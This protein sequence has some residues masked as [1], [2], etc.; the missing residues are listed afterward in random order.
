MTDERVAAVERGLDRLALPGPQRRD[1]RTPRARPA[2]SSIRRP[3]VPRRDRRWTHALVRTQTALR[4]HR[5]RRDERP[6]AGRAR[7]R[8]EVTGSDRAAGSPYAA[9]ARAGHRA[10]DRPRRRQRPGGRRGRLLERDRARTT[11]SARPARPSCTAPTCSASSRGCKP[12][13]AVSGTHGKTT[14]SSMLVH[15]LRG[16]GLDPSYLVG[17]EVRS[18]GANAGWGTGEWLVVE[19]D[20]SDRSLLKLAPDDRGA[21]PTPSSTTTRPTPRQRDV[22]D[23]FARVPRARRARGR[24]GPPGAARARGDARPSFDAPT[25]S[26]RRRLALRRSTASPSRCRPRRPQRPQRRRRADAMPARRRRPRAP[27]RRRSRDFDGRRPALRAPRH[28]RARARSSS[29]TTPTTRPRCAPRSRPPARSS[30]AGVV[31]VF[32]PHLYSRTQREA[33]AF[34]AALAQADLAVVA[35]HL[36]G[37][38]ARRGLPRRHRPAG[39]RGAADAGGGKRVAWAAHA[40][41]P[42]ERFLRARAARRRPAADAGRRRRR[43]RSGRDLVQGPA[44]RVEPPG[45]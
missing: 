7:A 40:T 31:A 3:G 19:A 44:A 37:A 34:G 24:L 45:Q 25:P 29:T 38:R 30:R 2:R 8:R 4:R 23:T 11:P 13:I 16:C 39:R 15:A 43:T 21:S 6:R 27:P 12:T 9:A 35:R 33:S 5:R 42:R 26:S 20:E 32:Q 10:V 17:G 1:S 28:D 36:P 41:T 18:T 22:D 14:T